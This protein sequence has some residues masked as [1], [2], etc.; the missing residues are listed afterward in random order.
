MVEPKDTTGVETM[1]QVGLDVLLREVGITVGRKEALRSGQERAAPVALDAS[2]FKD[3]GEVGFI[4]T[5][6]R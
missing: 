2:A 3:E 4:D 1:Q 6:E 5:T